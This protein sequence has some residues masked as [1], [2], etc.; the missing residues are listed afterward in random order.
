MTFTITIPAYKSKYLS[1]AIESVLAQTDSDFELIILNDNSPNDLTSI[2]KQYTDSRIRYY[3]NNVNIGAERL[4]DNWNKCLSYAQGEFIIC[5]GDDDKLR[6]N[7]LAEYRKLIQKFPNLDVYH[8]WTELIDE[9]SNIIE[10]LSKRPKHESVYMLMYERWQNRSQYIGD[11]LYRIKALRDNGG[12]YNLPLAWGSDDITAYIAAKQKGIANTDVPVFQYRENRFTITNTGN[13]E[14]KIEALQKEKKWTIEF[15]KTIPNN[16]IDTK[17]HT[18][19]MQELEHHF[20]YKLQINLINE[21][22]NKKIAQW[23][24]WI[25]KR[26]KLRLSLPVMIWILISGLKEKVKANR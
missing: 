24:Y 17:I 1:E 3:I 12:Y 21:L 22:R 9:N 13:T 6:P 5:M 8:G 15:L 18:Y 11:F 19:L 4:V 25:F 7:C 23:G 14:L 20:Q 26:K 16:E 2:V 10:L